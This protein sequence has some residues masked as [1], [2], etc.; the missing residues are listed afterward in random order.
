M[1]TTDEPTTTRLKIRWVR[2]HPTGDVSWHALQDE[3][4]RGVDPEALPH[5]TYCH[6][7][8]DGPIVAD[9]KD[10]HGEMGCESC[11][12]VVLRLL[13]AMGTIQ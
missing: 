2:M 3:S 11:K 7:E 10:T 1:T 6:R 9:L 12:S 13:E 8:A 5:P 4:E